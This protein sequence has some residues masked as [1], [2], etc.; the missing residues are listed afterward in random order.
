[1]KVDHAIFQTFWGPDAMRVLVYESDWPLTRAE[2]EKSPTI[3]VDGETHDYMKSILL[4]QR[5]QHRFNDE[6]AI[7]L[8]SIQ[9]RV[10]RAVRLS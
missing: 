2:F 7:W 10:G 1:M 8:L 9:T 3:E 6:Q 5:G 4:I